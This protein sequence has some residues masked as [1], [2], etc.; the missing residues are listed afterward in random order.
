MFVAQGEYGVLW[1]GGRGVAYGWVEGGCA[2]GEGAVGGVAHHAVQG[3]PDG[4]EDGRGGPERRLAEGEGFAVVG[5][6]C[7]KGGC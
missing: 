3:G 1:G 5:G 6:R 7:E 4:R 2:E